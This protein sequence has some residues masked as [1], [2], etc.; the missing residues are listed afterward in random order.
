ML[1]NGVD[2]THIETGDL[3]KQLQ[4][5]KKE[6]DL[7]RKQ[8]EAK[9]HSVLGKHNR[10]VESDPTTAYQA[11]IP[12]KHDS[13]LHLVSP[14]GYANSLSVEISNPEPSV[15]S[16]HLGAVSD[17]GGGSGANSGAAISGGIKPGNNPS[18]K[19]PSI[20]K[21]PST[22]EAKRTVVSAIVENNPAYSSARY[23]DKIQIINTNNHQPPKQGYNYFFLTPL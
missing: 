16:S 22:A 9:Q 12:S 17:A 18:P 4:A 23:Q 14:N 2:V 3:Q 20:L 7:L 11:K 21:H 19:H 15:S 1:Q 8:L 10:T 13:H 5:Q 6:N